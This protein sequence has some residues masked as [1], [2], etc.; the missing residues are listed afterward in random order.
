MK[1]KIKDKN[2][3]KVPSFKDKARN[4]YSFKDKTSAE[5]CYPEVKMIKMTSDKNDKSDNIL[6]PATSHHDELVK[7]DGVSGGEEDGRGWEGAEN[8]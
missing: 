7:A 3:S 2:K 5:R 4:F 1:I 6:S 8:F